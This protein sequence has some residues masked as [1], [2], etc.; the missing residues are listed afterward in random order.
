MV[1]QIGVCGPN[2]NAA[3][4]HLIY[5]RD[6]EMKMQKVGLPHNGYHQT[7]IINGAY[8]PQLHHLCTRMSGLEIRDGTGQGA[9]SPAV[10]ENGK[11]GGDVSGPF[12]RRG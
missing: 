6:D 9:H 11:S 1:T 7:A 2:D 12:R 3:L 10:F 8:E 5:A 4:R